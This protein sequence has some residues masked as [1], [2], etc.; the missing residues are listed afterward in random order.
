MYKIA[1]CDD[2][3]TH[4]DYVC[5]MV[6]NLLDIRQTPHQLDTFLS[7]KALKS[8]L[9]SDDY[10]V[11]ICDVALDNSNGIDLLKDLK[12]D[13]PQLQVIFISGFLE[14]N[15]EAYVVEHLYFLLKPINEERL[16][17]A[18]NKAFA[19]I[20]KMQSTQLSVTANRRN[21]IVKFDE[22]FF[23]ERVMRTY[24]IHT[25]GAKLVTYSKTDELQK[26]LDFRFLICHKSYIINMD[27]VKSFDSKCFIMQNGT[28]IPISQ[29]KRKEAQAAFWSY[30]GKI[31]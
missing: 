28:Q 16:A 29:S 17:L 2:N 22:I 11:V 6:K 7:A 1:I 8:A 12:Q 26:R 30:I 10:Q 18:L 23:F 27:K 31:D 21:V 25:N 15:P 5:E 20:A 24:E 9:L 4:I 3:S 14:Y 13:L 19:E